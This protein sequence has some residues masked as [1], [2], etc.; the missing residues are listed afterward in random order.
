MAGYLG[1]SYG[2]Y[3]GAVY[4]SLF[5][6]KLN[7]NVLDSSVNP[8]WI[9]RETFRQ[10]AVAARANIDIY[11][12]WLGER[13]FVYGLDKSQA[14]VFASTEALTAKL[15]KA[16]I[17][18]PDFGEVDGTTVDALLGWYSRFRP[19]WDE[20]GE[21]IKS[22]K[23]AADGALASD[24]AVLKDAGKAA[25]MMYDLAIAETREGVFETITC[26][27]DWPKDLAYYYDE[28]RLFREK[29]PHFGGVAR[30][31]PWNCT[32]R[33]FTPPDKVT[34]LKRAGYPTGLVIQ[35]E[36]DAQTAYAGGPAMATKLRDHLVSVADEGM[37]G[38][39]GYNDCASDIIDRY[40]INGVLP[41]THVTCAG[42][43]RPDVPADSAETVSQRPAQQL[44]VSESVR[45]T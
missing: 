29:Y 40:L 32:F 24:S 37:H 11:D 35:A 6:S 41:S 45:R 4:G 9:W 5:P 10:Q 13:N 34:D 16:P 12:T 42:D 18:D 3:L 14:E 23:A 31:A 39:Y 36:G 30:V 33:S 26:E 17:N 44:N 8:D 15:N 20:L 38:L 25:R 7:R 43:P 1:F 21:V 19:L 27:A 22:F 2:T 28:M